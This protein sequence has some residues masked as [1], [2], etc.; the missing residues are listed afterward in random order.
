MKFNIRILLLLL[1]I[2]V[3]L[4]GCPKVQKPTPPSS[5][6][7]TPATPTPLPTSAPTPIPP[8]PTPTPS[9]TLTPQLL[10][11]K[12]L[13]QD[14]EIKISTEQVKKE[15]E[16]IVKNVIKNRPKSQHNLGW[17]YQEGNKLFQD[18]EKAAYWYTKATEQ[19][20]APSQTNLGYLYLMGYG[21]EQSDK[22]A[23]EY[24]QK[25]AEHGHPEG[26][27]WYGHMYE[28]YG[29]EGRGELDKNILKAIELYDESASATILSEEYRSYTY[30]AISK[31]RIDDVKKALEELSEKDL[32]DEEEDGVKNVLNRLRPLE[33]FWVGRTYEKGQGGLAENPQKAVENY[34]TSVIRANDIYGEKS[35]V[36]KEM[37]ERVKKWLEKL[38]DKEIEEAN[39]ALFTLNSIFEK[40]QL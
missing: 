17:M 28:G 15:I 27:Y 30:P 21:V 7:P 22:K 33:S 14:S 34:T 38:S 24:F 40:Y 25:S 19:D 35:E 39:E 8:T 29:E 6:T 4:Y 36:A 16:R 20:Y 3:S 31:R 11:S 10:D 18:Y 5:P 12:Y 9:V 1:A 32:E 2:T 13:P 23:I 37:I 26:L